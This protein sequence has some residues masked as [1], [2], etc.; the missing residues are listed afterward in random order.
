VKENA[1]DLSIFNEKRDVIEFD[2][3]VGHPMRPAG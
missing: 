2:W 1:N 3:Y